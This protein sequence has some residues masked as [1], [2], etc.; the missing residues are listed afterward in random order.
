MP[1]DLSENSYKSGMESPSL[2]RNVHGKI[3]FMQGH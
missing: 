1:W 2:S 3:L